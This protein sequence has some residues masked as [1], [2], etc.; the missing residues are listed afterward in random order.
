MLTEAEVF[1]VRIPRDTARGSVAST[2]LSLDADCGPVG[3]FSAAVRRFMVIAPDYVRGCNTYYG[4]GKDCALP[5]PRLMNGQRGLDVGS[6]RRWC[7]RHGRGVALRGVR[8]VGVSEAAGVP[9]SIVTVS[10]WIET[11]SLTAI[12]SENS[13]TQRHAKSVG[14]HYM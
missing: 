9:R 5:R 7:C 1:A 4:S 12:C 3:L 14:T 8:L 10:G 13:T 6:C 2:G 11:G